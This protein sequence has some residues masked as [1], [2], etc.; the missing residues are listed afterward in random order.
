MLPEIANGDPDEV[1]AVPGEIGRASEGPGEPGRLDGLPNL[2]GGAAAAPVPPV[3]A[4]GG[5]AAPS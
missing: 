1:W 5:T 2:S 3:R 4:G